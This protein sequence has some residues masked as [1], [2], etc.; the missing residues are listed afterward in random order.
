MSETVWEQLK[1]ER[2]QLQ[3]AGRLPYWM[4]TPSWQMLKS[5]YTTEDYPD[6]RA[7]AERIA[8]RAA[9]YMPY[10][11]LWSGRFFSLMWKG[12]MAASTPVLSN[13]GTGR[14]SPVSCSGNLVLDNVG[15]FYEKQKEAALLSKNGFGTSS[16]LG[17]I[18]ERGSRFG[19]DGTASGVVPVL[20]DFIQVSQDISQGS[21]R[22]GAWAGY[23]EIEGG[24]YWE[25]VD[26]LAKHPDDCNLGWNIRDSFIE[27]LEASDRDAIKRYQ[28]AMATK[29][30]TGKGYFFFPDKVN[31]LAPPMYKD[32]N[33]EVLASNLCTEI[34]LYQDEDHTFTCV[35]S[36]MNLA[37]F[38]EWKD[39]DA[40]F[41]ATV[42]LDCVAEDFIQVGQHIEGL[43]R[44]VRFTHKSRALGLGALGFHT[45]LQDRMLPIDGMEAHFT[46]QKMFK[47]LHDESL[48]ASEWL[49]ET[50]GEPEWCKGYGVRNTHRTA[51]AP[52]T[53]S[54]LIC[55]AVSQGIEPV[56]K[57]V[58]SQG[59]SA[60][61]IDRINPSIIS[62]MKR[63]GIY[64][65][66]TIAKL[67]RADGSI[68]DMDE[69]TDE[70][71]LVF[72]T[73]FEVPQDALIRLAST[74]QLYICQAQSLNLFF[75]AE[76]DPAVISWVHQQAFRDP[77]IL[78]L[79]Y[80]RSQSGVKG[81]TGE[82]TACEA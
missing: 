34:T 37:K 17:L 78:S 58:Y 26:Y 21:T 33:L 12:W 4:T 55:G 47:H 24:D 56:Y 41:W 49:A 44:A 15:D 81:S 82:C 74:R 43:E 62:L 46:N 22:R 61:E 54:A 20:K 31:R 29:M 13:M 2:K 76:E 38:D 40:V 10:S 57:N 50:K 70:E 7:L 64:N 42:F 65:D 18:R 73:A 39:T 16:Y 1:N 30:K 6:F 52:N 59:S 19:Q 27:R 48:R 9:S 5:K 72:R 77:N 63:K 75:S 51:V 60:G 28:R 53:S 25:A 69:F 67:V 79:Y 3:A 36:S 8:D 68:Q 32:M 66:D 14:G 80:V 35:L 45:Y 11:G 23:L 71:K